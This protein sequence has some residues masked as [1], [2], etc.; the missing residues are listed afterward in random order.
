MDALLEFLPIFEAAGFKPVKSWVH[1]ELRPGV[2]VMPYPVYREEVEAFMAAASQEAWADFRYT[3]KPANDWIRD[4]SFIARASL[5]QIKTMLTYVV[6]GERFCDGH[7][8][9][10]IE[11]GRVQGIL[12][13]L[14]ELRASAEDR[15]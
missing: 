9:G 10:L 7:V 15:A 11:K 6:R 5:E 4:S 14:G 8:S 1:G 2:H 3:K 12:R 13:R